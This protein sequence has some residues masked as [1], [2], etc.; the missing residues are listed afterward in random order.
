M[1]SAY[2]PSS[3]DRDEAVVRLS[4]AVL[5]ES[6]IDPEPVGFPA[7]CDMWAFRAS[8]IPTVVIGPGSIEQAHVV[9]EYLDLGQLRSAVDVYERLLLKM[10]K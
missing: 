8:R 10:L 2:P 6:G 9:D 5:R 3:T 1:L 4:S 7:G